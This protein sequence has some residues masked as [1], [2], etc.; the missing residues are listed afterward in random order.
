MIDAMIQDAIDERETWLASMG[1]LERD[2]EVSKNGG[3]EFIWHSTI[4]HD[5]DEHL[6]RVLLPYSIQ[7]LTIIK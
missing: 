6:V 3:Q 7:K 2:V 5:G 1:C 4:D